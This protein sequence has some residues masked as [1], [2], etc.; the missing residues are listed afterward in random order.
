MGRFPTIEDP[1]LLEEGDVLAP[2]FDAQGLLPAIVTDAKSGEVLMFAFMNDEA[3]ALTI[4]TGAAHFWSRSRNS[5]WRKG[6]TSGNELRVVD[7]RID[8]D[9]DVVWLK[10]EMTGAEACCHT[11]RLSCFYRRIPFGPA[12]GDK[13]TQ[14]HTER[15][16]DPADVYGSTAPEKKR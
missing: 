14:V 16:F 10:A 1:A 2:R 13:L 11:G 8:C 6:E 3:L 12:A 9:Q 5:L 15:H 7:L 4:E